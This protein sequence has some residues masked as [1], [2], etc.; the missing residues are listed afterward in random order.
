LLFGVLYGATQRWT[1][2]LTLLVGMLALIYVAG[3]LA[4][5]PRFVD[6]ELATARP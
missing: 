3:L 6:D 1:L 4:S 2:P 5:R